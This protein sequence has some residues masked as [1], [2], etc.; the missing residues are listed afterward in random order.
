MVPQVRSM[1]ARSGPSTPRTPYP[2][3]GPDAVC[4]DEPGACV[5]DEQAASAKARAVSAIAGQR[6]RRCSCCDGTPG[7]GEAFAPFIQTG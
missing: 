1:D 4:R 2:L 3:I 7:R 5:D 6:R